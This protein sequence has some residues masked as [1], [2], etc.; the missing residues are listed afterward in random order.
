[1]IRRLTFENF[2]S[3]RD[4]GELVLTASAKTPVDNSFVKSRCGDQMTVLGG[5]FGPNASGKTNLL[6]VA[7]FLHF[8]LRHSYHALESD[9][10][11][12]VDS[13]LDGNGRPVRLSV[14]FEGCGRVYRYE[15]SLTPTSVKEERLTLRSDKTK[16]FRT[17]LLRTEGKRLPR[18]SQESD[19]TD[20][21]ALRSLLR[22]RP[23]ASMVAVGL[24]TG[25]REFEQVLSSLGRVETNVDRLGKAE[26]LQG[27]RGLE[28]IDC[29]RFF[30]EN[31][32]FQADLEDRLKRADLG[33]SGFS[34]REREVIDSKSERTR[35]L[36]IPYVVHLSGEHKFELPLIHESAGT[37]RLF[38]LLA[39]F[40]PVLTEGGVAFI[41]EMESDLHPHLIPLLLDL[42]VDKGTNP[43]RAQLIFTCHHVEI[44]NQL[45]KEQIVLVQKDA[46]NVSRVQRL[47]DIKGVRREDNFFA[48]YNAG[49]Y[50]AVPEPQLF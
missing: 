48:H 22:D 46:E 34:I 7:S 43:K 6:K 50:E 31:P 40:L 20:L 23:N 27:S 4:S 32:H 41:D 14:E 8:F 45:A 2:C 36:P 21:D 10:P 19:F 33:I 18:L 12:P 39:A 26:M 47:A 3:F 24:V 35:T 44:L 49:R 42:F 38:V 25:R 28:I 29:A 9:A 5:V 16:A 13:F 15:V 17:L 1:M 37:K 11:V 30:Q